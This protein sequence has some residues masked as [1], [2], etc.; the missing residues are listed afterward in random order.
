MKKSIL[1]MAAGM[2]SR[3]GG[4]KQLSKFGESQSALLDY[5]LHDAMSAGFGKVIFVIRKDIEKEFRESLSAKYESKLDVRYAF[6]ELDKLPQGF[7]KPLGRTKPWGTGHA[8]LCA[9]DE[10]S[11]GF[12]AIN[13]DDYYGASSYKLMS[14]FLDNAKPNL[15]ALAGYKLSNT[16]SE[17]G[18]VS[19]GVCFSTP[20]MFLE[21]VSEFTGLQKKD[22]KVISN[23]GNIFTGDELVSLNFWAFEQGFINILEEYF[24]DFLKA[25]LT[26]EKSEFYLPSAVDRAI[27]SGRAKAKILPTPE[28]WQGVTYKEDTPIVEAFLRTRAGI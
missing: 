1:V 10:I 19:R 25:R 5:A 2:G 6:Q 22:G 28:I 13:A 27:K 12:L 16:L 23:E 26:E 15:Y 18:G 3:F 20:D 17:N 21:T 8:V 14:E 4:L 7:S 24:Y 9:K 11:E